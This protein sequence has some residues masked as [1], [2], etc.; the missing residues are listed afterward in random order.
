MSSSPHQ[1]EL[2][3]RSLLLVRRRMTQNISCQQPQTTGS[4]ENQQVDGDAEIV[5]P[6]EC[7]DRAFRLRRRMT[8]RAI[9]AGRRDRIHDNIEVNPQSW[10]PFCRSFSTAS[11]A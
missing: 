3:T 8:R 1:R 4:Q 9:I 6:D 7:P 10:S 5:L 11:Q 2:G